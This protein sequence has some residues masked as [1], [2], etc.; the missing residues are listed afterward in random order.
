MPSYLSAIP[1]NVVT[2]FLGAGKSTAILNLLKEKPE[3]ER[4]AILVNE[5]GEVGI[6]GGL[7]GASSGREVF[8]REVPGGCMCCTAGLPM[9]MAMNMLLARA[10]PDR[11]LIEPTGLGHPYE[12][13]AALT[14]DYYQQLLDLRATLTMV[15]ARKISDERYT[16]HS[17]FN[18][19]LKIADVIVATKSDGY[20]ATDL[21]K[22]KQYLSRNAWLAERQLIVPNDGFLPLT[23][24][25]KPRKAW[26][27]P[28]PVASSMAAVNKTAEGQG[29][30]QTEFPPAGYIKLS[31]SGDG[32]VSHGW[33]FRDSFVFDRKALATLIR[34]TSA[35]RVKALIR[36]TEGHVG[37][38]FSGERVEELMLRPLSD[39][40]LELIA[41]QDFSVAE[42]EAELLAAV[43]TP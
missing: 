18:E 29:E 38:N 40:R 2:G 42:F 41:D 15:D 30:V 34:G 17:T 14:T 35:E 6:D 32:F 20:R 24:L 26:Q 22:L 16:K 8:V 37:Y 7:L 31:N 13:L 23:L 19:Q 27:L 11:L 43:Q 4:W 9:Q 1:T 10:K 28:N 36:T 39:S 33:I 3:G 12:V 21:E 25:D 5:F